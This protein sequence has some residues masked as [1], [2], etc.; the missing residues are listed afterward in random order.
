MDGK[1]VKVK[2]W[3]KSYPTWKRFIQ[4]TDKTIQR[5]VAE[6]NQKPGAAAVCYDRVP[7]SPGG[8]HNS[9]EE[10]ALERKQELLEQVAE[11]KARSNTARK[12]VLL[13]D[14]AIASLDPIDFK[15][16]RCKDMD[17]MTWTRTALEMGYSEGGC[18]YQYRSALK[19][20]AFLLFGNEEVETEGQETT[21]GQG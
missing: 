15:L 5:L 21:A 7:G 3:L 8:W 18:R 6:M 1:E 20:L 11:L 10:I 2:A 19:E 17:R 16:L 13:L 9:Q 4:N 12:N 14:T